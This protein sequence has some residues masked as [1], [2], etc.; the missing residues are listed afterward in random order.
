MIC[1]DEVE[2]EGSL[3]SHSSLSRLDFDRAGQNYE[4]GAA[5]AGTAHPLCQRSRIVRTGLLFVFRG[6]TAGSKRSPGNGVNC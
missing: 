6:P 2:E 1:E 4:R 5:H 3:R